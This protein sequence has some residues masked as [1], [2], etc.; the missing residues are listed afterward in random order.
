MLE[1]AGMGAYDPILDYAGMVIQFGYV[2]QFSVGEI[3]RDPNPSCLMVR[4]EVG[5]L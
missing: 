4:C 2:I 3:G 1:Q 5:G